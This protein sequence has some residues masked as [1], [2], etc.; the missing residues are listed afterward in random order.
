MNRRTLPAAAV[1]FAATAAFLLTAC[2]GGSD[3]SSDK[4]KIAGADA[5]P[6]KK[7]TSPE[8]S[9]SN[10]GIERPKVELPKGVK[11]VF[12]GR[13]TG[14]ATKDAVL[15]DNERGINAESAAILS[16]DQDSSALSFYNKGEALL[17]EA[18]YVQSFLDAGISYKGTIRYFDRRVTLVDAKTATLVYCA[19]ESGASNTDRKTGKVKAAGQTKP[20]DNFV[21]YNTR[22]TLNAKG[23]WQNTKGFGK[24]GAASCA[25]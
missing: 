25:K 10:D 18:K 12:E 1:V 24:R 4:D 5:A 19:D 7:S 14:D 11:N 13:S 9:P 3:D 6:G 23:V 17:S 15:A 8:A 22:L 20:K 16:G 21:L 2:G